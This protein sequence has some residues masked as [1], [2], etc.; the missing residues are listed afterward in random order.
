MNDTPQTDAQAGWVLDSTPVHAQGFEKD[1]DGSYVAADF[2]RQLERENARMAS[3][4]REIMAYTDPCEDRA[5]VIAEA[6]LSNTKFRD[7]EDGAP[8]SP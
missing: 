7:G 3:A 6:A 2:A 8:H 1:P 5:H 4:L